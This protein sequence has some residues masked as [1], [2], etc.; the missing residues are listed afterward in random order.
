MTVAHAGHQAVLLSNGKV[1]IVGG[2]DNV[3]N[4][5][6]RIVEV[7]EPS[8]GK[9]TRVG[10]APFVNL[11]ALIPLSTGKVLA[12][13]APFNANYP[14]GT[15]IYDPA[16]D[17]WSAAASAQFNRDSYTATLLTNGQVLIAGGRGD[18][19][20]LVSSELYDPIADSWSRTGD[21]VEAHSS[22]T[23]VIL[24]DGKVLVSGGVGVSETLATAEI[25]TPPGSIAATKLAFTQQPPATATVG[26]QFTTQVTVE[27]ASGNQ[28]TSAASIKLTATGGSGKLSCSANPQNAVAGVATF[29]CS[30][31]QPGSDTLQATAKGLKGATSNAVTIGCPVG[32]Y[33]AS[34]YPNTT[35][36]GNPT[37]SRCENN[38]SHAVSGSWPGHGLPSSNFSVR[39]LGS[40]DFSG[41]SP[42]TQSTAY[43]ITAKADNGIRVYADGTAVIDHWTA[44]P[45]SDYK[46]SA[47]LQEGVQQIAVDYF[48][49]TG[50]GSIQVGWSCQCV[51]YV[52]NV[53]GLKGGISQS[54][55]A[56]TMGPFL[57][58]NGFHTAS[59]PSEV[60]G[61]VAVMQPS[62]NSQIDQTIGH[63]AVVEKVVDNGNGTWT[64][65]VKAA[66]FGT[67]NN[68]SQSF[69]CNNMSSTPF[70]FPVSDIGNSIVFYHQ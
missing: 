27:D 32:Q 38:I 67:K 45:V 40:F 66:N 14:P 62:F 35:L 19:P 57:E 55:F 36:S 65:T 21:M 68:A 51:E 50:P 56:D 42:V 18:S 46:Q 13:L 23:T 34:Y 3:T 4:G 64:I 16:T 69:S 52:K 39:W 47:T 37:F 41:A 8:T 7:Y 29:T 43:P 70:T 30:V 31:N 48:H 61:A 28:V 24:A 15:E 54:G 1:L 20:V 17:T 9:W 59:T 60:K 53:F 12:L 58:Q 11:Q 33:A 63:V 22:A 49:S 44:A 2:D 6:S 5:V 10:D 26:Q 25:Y